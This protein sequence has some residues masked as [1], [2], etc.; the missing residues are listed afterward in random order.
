[1]EGK[2]IPIA[3]IERNRAWIEAVTISL[4]K[5]DDLQLL[6]ETMRDAGKKCAAQILEKA[7]GHFGSTP[8]SVDELIEA[9]N[10]RR[11]DVLKASTFLVR[12]GNKAHFKL[13]KCSCDLVESGLAEP[14]PSFC[15]CSAGMLENLFIP[16]C[17]GSVKTQIIKSIG[18]GDA[19]CQFLIHF[20]E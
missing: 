6:S 16:F 5:R 4:G 19:Y 11:R 1:M 13:E 8:E 15:R 20:D 10:R 18:N 2:K 17:K 14:N 3:A 12:D 7:I 9:I